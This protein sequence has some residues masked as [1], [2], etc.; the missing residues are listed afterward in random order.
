MQLYICKAQDLA[1][2]KLESEVQLICFTE[3]MTLREYKFG[4]VYQKIYEGIVSGK[5]D[6]IGEYSSLIENCNR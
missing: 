1:K 5:D 2:E 6:K 3:E 4:G